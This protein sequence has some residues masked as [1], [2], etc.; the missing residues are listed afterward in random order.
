M[1][2]ESLAR[3]F[4]KIGADLGDAMAKELAAADPQLAEKVAHAVEHGERLMLSV[5]FDPTVP[6]VRLSTIDDYGTTKR[7]MHVAA[8]RRRPQ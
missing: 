2:V 7:V 8:S 6:T 5:E 1:T 4:V 3:D